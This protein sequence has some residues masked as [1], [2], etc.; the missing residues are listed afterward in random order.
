[1]SCDVIIL[2]IWSIWMRIL[3]PRCSRIELLDAR[4]LIRVP[5]TNSVTLLVYRLAVQSELPGDSKK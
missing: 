5:K 2:S 1:M 3:V 4:N